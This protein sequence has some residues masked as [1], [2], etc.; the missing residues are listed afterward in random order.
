MAG[1]AGSCAECA[2]ITTQI[3]REPLEPY[4]WPTGLRFAAAGS[5]GQ[6]RTAH[7][8]APLVVLLATALRAS[9][10]L[11][12][13]LRVDVPGQQRAASG[14][15]HCRCRTGVVA[16]E[17]AP[18]SQARAPIHRVSSGGKRG[19]SAIAGAQPAFGELA[20][21][22]SP[23]ARRAWVGVGDCHTRSAVWETGGKLAGDLGWR[24]AWWLRRERNIHWSLR[25]QNLA[26]GTDVGD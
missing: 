9:A 10:G 17:T 23:R 21:T 1:R 13:Y 20:R 19:G 3:T 4:A 25:C 26:P 5:K 15:V 8:T 2:G 24:A 6:R 18:A 16:R 12:R 11:G 22:A 14:R 7:W